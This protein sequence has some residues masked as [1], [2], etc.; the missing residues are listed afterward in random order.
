MK[1]NIEYFIRP[2]DPLGHYFEVDLIIW[3]PQSLQQV[4][5]PAWIPGS[6][7][8]RDFSKQIVQIHAYEINDKRHLI[9]P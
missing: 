2:A 1:A 9:S 7:M 3:Q 8:I 5:M 6:Y 4:Q